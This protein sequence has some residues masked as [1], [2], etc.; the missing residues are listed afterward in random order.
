MPDRIPWHQW[1]NY[2]ARPEHAAGKEIRERIATK[3]RA[4]PR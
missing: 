2:E 4:S 1:E 3:L